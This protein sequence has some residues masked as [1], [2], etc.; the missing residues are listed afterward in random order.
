MHAAI[1]AGL[2]DDEDIHSLALSFLSPA[3]RRFEPLTGHP[4]ETL[5]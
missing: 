4:T 2:E 5:R 1:A 3:G